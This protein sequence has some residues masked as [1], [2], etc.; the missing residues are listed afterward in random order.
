MALPLLPPEDIAE[1]FLLLTAIAAVID[2]PNVQ[3]FI[4]YLDR[5]WMG[6]EWLFSKLK[7]CLC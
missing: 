1:G 3:D 4:G 7:L 6:S 2:N 5:Q